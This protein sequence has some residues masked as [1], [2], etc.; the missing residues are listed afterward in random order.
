MKQVRLTIVELE[1]IQQALGYYRA[2]EMECSNEVEQ[3]ATI[4]AHSKISA[5]LLR[6][7]QRRVRTKPRND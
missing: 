1:A 2:G 6:R 5:M 4:S 3:A 7:H